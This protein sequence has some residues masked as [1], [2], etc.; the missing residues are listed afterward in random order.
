MFAIGL[1]EKSS[2]GQVNYDEGGRSV[3]ASSGGVAVAR[4]LEMTRWLATTSSTGFG[5]LQ[6]RGSETLWIVDA[7]VS[8]VANEAP[9]AAR[10]KRL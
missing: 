7:G 2:R 3:V 8:T 10:R 6:L 4:R 1:V 5:A 9:R